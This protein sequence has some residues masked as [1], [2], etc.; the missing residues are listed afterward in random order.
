MRAIL[1]RF[2][3]AGQSW[4]QLSI[5]SMTI[6]FPKRRIYGN[7]YFSG[8]SP[9]SQIKEAPGRLPSI[10]AKPQMFL[11]QNNPMPNWHFGGWHILI[12]S[13]PMK[14]DKVMKKREWSHSM[15]CL[16]PTV[17]SN[18]RVHKIWLWLI[19]LSKKYSSK[20]R[21]HFPTVWQIET[22]HNP[23]HPGSLGLAKTFLV[24]WS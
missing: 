10:S 17:E 23:C 18:F 3:R 12:P 14:R 6:Y 15:Q 24:Y 4:R 20:I 5:F 9:L 13:K 1:A 21:A 22:R 19:L 11:A 16:S 8:V 7:P 2:V